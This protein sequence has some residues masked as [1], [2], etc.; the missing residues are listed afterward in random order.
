MA[1]A[2]WI[3]CLCL[4]AAVACAGGSPADGGASGST[5]GAASATA[6]SSST[7]AGS[8]AGGSTGSGSG[9]GGGTA[10]ASAGSGS[11]GG[12]VEA[13]HPPFP[14]LTSQGGPVLSDPLIVA[15]TYEDFPFEGVLADAGPTV[16]RWLPGVAGEYG[17]RTASFTHVLLPFAAP[18]QADGMTDAPALLWGLIQDGGVPVADGGL[19][20]TVYVLF[21]PPTTDETYLGSAAA[22]AQSAEPGGYHAEAQDQPEDFTFAILASCGAEPVDALTVELGHEVAEAA[23]DPR[24]FTAPAYTFYAS[25]APP[26]NPW[27]LGG[28]EIADLC[29][30]DGLLT[31]Q[32]GTALPLLWSNGA[33]ADGGA[34]CVP[35]S[36]P[37]YDASAAPPGPVPLAAGQSATFRLTGWS[38]APV[39]DWNLSTW[40]PPWV[41]Q[42]ATLSLDRTQLND[43]ETATLTVTMPDGGWSL[44]PIQYIQIESGPDAVWDISIVPP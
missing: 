20:Q 13:P 38:T 42:V 7:G 37:F 21:Y 4:F 1:N 40:M 24:P 19:A 43:G 44:T 11:A 23:T 8:S 10:G 12:F 31:R 26:T 9:G 15:V 25:P 34:P 6:S 22:C 18:A 41:P 17:V 27:S 5:G 14:V 36:G 3:P 28:G 33:A 30:A 16:A 32:G 39:A 2:R 35:W 29:E